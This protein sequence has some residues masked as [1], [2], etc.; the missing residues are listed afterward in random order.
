M[1]NSMGSSKL[2]VMFVTFLALAAGGSAAESG[3]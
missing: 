3:G 2:F 1:T